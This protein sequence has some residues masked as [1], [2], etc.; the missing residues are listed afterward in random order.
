MVGAP[1]DVGAFSIK[2]NNQS[3]YFI[4]GAGIEIVFPS[5]FQ[6]MQAIQ[7]NIQELVVTK[8]LRSEGSLDSNPHYSQ[9]LVLKRVTLVDFMVLLEHV[10]L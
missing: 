2:G 1:Q 5:Q 6:L 4:G 9:T 3:M 10:S 7:V 8:P